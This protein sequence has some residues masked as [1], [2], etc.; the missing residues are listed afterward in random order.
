MTATAM[1]HGMD[2]E[3]AAVER[4]E[5]AAAA[6]PREPGRLLSI[7]GVVRGEDVI[8][9]NG[10]VGGITGDNITVDRAFARAAIAGREVHI[11]R[12]GAGI[13]ISAGTTDITQ[14]GAQ[15]VVSGGSI[16]MNQAGSALAI[17]RQ[18]EVGE[19]GTVVF[20]ITPN[21]QVNSGGRL[22]FGPRVAVPILGALV[23]LIVGG[24]AFAI[25]RA[26]SRRSAPAA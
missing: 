17:A 8:L 15:A 9:R 14:G 26:R 10:V 3:T 2:E 12:A 18:I 1:E 13:V 20:G 25:S 11:Q 23:A 5:A 6:Q 19:R 24:V 16:Q 4:P 7:T 21:L 22:V